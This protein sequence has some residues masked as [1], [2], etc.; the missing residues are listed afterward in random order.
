[1]GIA[2]ACLAPAAV[3]TALSLWG[4]ADQQATYLPAFVGEDVPAAA[5][6][7]LEP[8]RCSTRSSFI[9]RARR[10]GGGYVLDGVKS[11][12]P[13]AADAELFVD[14]GRARGPRPGAVHRRVRR[15]P[16]S[17]IEPEPAMGIR[18]AAHRRRLILEGVELAP[19][20]AAG[21]RRPCR[22]RRVRRAGPARLVRARGRHRPGGTRL[23]DPVRQRAQG[24]RRADL[25]PPGG[26]VHRRQHRR[27]SS[28][29][30]GWPPTGPPAAS[31]RGSGSRARPR[32]RGGCAP[33]TG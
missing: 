30:C 1:M 33:S 7:L 2:V 27:S 23:R 4:D 9:P 25:Q 5:L 6:A 19:E 32:W 18:A 14:R 10:H 16:G 12:V 15:P 26:R 11:L 29:G 17:S 21:R 22:V 13:R 20:R 31:T 3:S 28:T 24:V 8:R